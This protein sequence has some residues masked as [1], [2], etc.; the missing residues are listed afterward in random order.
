M[1]KLSLEEI[2][3]IV[4]QE[5][6]RLCRF[7]ATRLNRFRCEAGWDCVGLDRQTARFLGIDFWRRL[8]KK[9]WKYYSLHSVVFVAALF[10]KRVSIQFY[11]APPRSNVAPLIRPS[12]ASLMNWRD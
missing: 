12:V 1:E 3:P 11:D 7:Q 2:V 4:R 10:N 8:E 9:K 6:R 5:Y